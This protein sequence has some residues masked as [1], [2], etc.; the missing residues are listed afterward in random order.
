MPLIWSP[1]TIIVLVLFLTGKPQLSK[2]PSYG[3]RVQ[4]RYTPVRAQYPPH[5]MDTAYATDKLNRN[6]G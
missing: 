3:D 1:R 2:L 4:L 6:E 5:I